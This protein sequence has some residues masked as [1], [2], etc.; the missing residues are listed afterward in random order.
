MSLLTEVWDNWDEEEKDK[1]S[2]KDIYTRTNLNTTSNIHNNNMS[3]YDNYHNTINE[4]V[5]NKLIKENNNLVKM[6]NRQQGGG[7]DR[8][9]NISNDTLFYIILGYLVIF[10]LDT[11]SNYN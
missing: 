6:I 9:L 1:N 10:V 7:G 5:I 2:G 8:L 11:I 3:E 4:N